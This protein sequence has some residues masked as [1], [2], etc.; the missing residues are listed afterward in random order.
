[1]TRILHV[2]SS[3]VGGGAETQLKLLME[4]SRDKNLEVGVIFLYDDKELSDRRGITF[5][6]LSRGRKMDLIGLSKRIFRA[7]DDFKPDLIHT[8]LPEIMCIPAALYARQ[9][10]I[11]CLGAQRRSLAKNVGWRCKLRDIFIPINHLLNERVVTNFSHDNEP[12]YIKFILDRRMATTVRNGLE[13]CHILN[14]KVGS[15]LREEAF[16]LIFV[17][18]LVKHKNVDLLISAIS[19]LIADGLDVQLSIYGEGVE[20]DT[21]HEQA[22]RLGLIKSNAIEFCGYSSK[23]RDHSSPYDCFVLPTSAEGMPNVLIEAMSAGLPTITT[24]IYEISSFVENRVQSLLVEPESSESIVAGIKEV[25]SDLQLRGRL[26][27]GGSDLA[28]TFSVD[29]MAESYFCIYSEM[30]GRQAY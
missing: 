30:L 2:I 7:I 26:I 22:T 5:Y 12:F 10:G 29:S 19:E 3:L 9:I 11:P 14:P 8:W 27:N 4:K 23:W 21:L 25:M 18:R 13:N 6:K 20:R 1:M 16:K 15:F 24:S 28:K 17:G